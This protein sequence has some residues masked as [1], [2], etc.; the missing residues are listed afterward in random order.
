MIALASRFAP[1]PVD[2]GDGPMLTIGAMALVKPVLIYTHV[3]FERL[4]IDVGLLDEHYSLMIN[5]K[6]RN[7][8]STLRMLMRGTVRLKGARARAPYYIRQ[9]NFVEAVGAVFANINKAIGL[10]QRGVMEIRI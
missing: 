3:D 9:H 5:C 2:I 1:V 6:P 8:K 7:V 10:V 4:F